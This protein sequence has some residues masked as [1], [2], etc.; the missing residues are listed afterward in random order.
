V[1]FSGVRATT[2]TLKKLLGFASS[3]ARFAS[4]NSKTLL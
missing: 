2:D 4:M 3:A 1:A